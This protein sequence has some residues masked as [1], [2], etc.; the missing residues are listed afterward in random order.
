MILISDQQKIELLRE[1]LFNI[2]L[3]KITKIAS[4]GR[5]IKKITEKAPPEKCKKICWFLQR[6]QHTQIN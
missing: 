3:E 1:K 6:N 4:I 2:R 5:K